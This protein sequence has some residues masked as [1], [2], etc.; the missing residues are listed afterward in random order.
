MAPSKERPGSE[1]AIAR[2][3]EALRST[4]G[5]AEPLLAARELC[6]V[7]GTA[8]NSADTPVASYVDAAL[9]LAQRALSGLR[10]QRVARAQSA[11]VEPLAELDDVAAPLDLLLLSALVPEAE[12]W[13]SAPATQQGVIALARGALELASIL[14]LAEPPSAEAGPPAAEDAA[15]E[16]TPATPAAITR[17][18]LS[19]AERTFLERSLALL[20]EAAR[21][22]LV[23]LGACSSGLFPLCLDVLREPALGAAADGATDGSPKSGAAEEGQDAEAPAAGSPEGGAPEPPTGGGQIGAA[24]HACALLALARCAESASARAALRGAGVFGAQLL[25]LAEHPEAGVRSHALL[26]AGLGAHDAQARS[27]LVGCGLARLVVRQLGQF[28]QRGVGLPAAGAGAPGAAGGADGASTAAARAFDALA[29]G[30]MA[31]AVCVRADPRSAAPPTADQALHA[32]GA[33]GGATAAALAGLRALA[34]AAN[35]A[36]HELSP[37][38]AQ[39]GAA[40]LPS[41]LLGHLAALLEFA[42]GSPGAEQAVE[43]LGPTAAAELAAALLGCC[44]LPRAGEAAAES[45]APLQ[46]EVPLVALRALGHALRSAAL[47]DAAYALDAAPLLARLLA[48]AAAPASAGAAAA[49]AAPDAELC[50]AAA[51]AV[52]AL[53]AHPDALARLL[54]PPSDALP[55]LASLLLL[56]GHAEQR[57]AATAVAALALAPEARVR[58]CATRDAADAAS[59]TEA[60]DTDALVSRIAPALIGR[61]LGS[62]DASV[63]QAGAHALG[64]LCRGEGEALWLVEEGAVGALDALR[65][66]SAPT[67]GAAAATSALRQLARRHA[68]TS[69]WLRR[70][71]PAHLRVARDALFYALAPGSPFL[72]ARD[73]VAGL[74]LGPNGAPTREVLTASA[75]SDAELAGLLA[76]CSA[77]LAGLRAGEE[78]LAVSL[79]AAAVCARMGG[80]VD[81]GGY[82]R[83]SCAH[84]VH[85]AQL[86]AGSDA[87]PLA[88]LPAGRAWHRAIL[89]KVL[90]DLT[91]PPQ[92]PPGGLSAVDLAQPPL[93]GLSASM[94]ARQAER[95]AHL[96]HAW[97]EVVL[98]GMRRH[99]AGAGGA[100]RGRAAGPLARPT[101]PARAPLLSARPHC[102]TP[103]GSSARSTPAP[104]PPQAAC[105]SST[106]CTRWGGRTRSARRRPTGERRDGQRGAPAPAPAWFDLIF[107]FSTPTVPLSSSPSSLPPPNTLRPRRLRPH[108]YCLTL[109]L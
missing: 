55:P 49:A 83:Y 95:G 25:A 32:H 109:T 23:K 41:G 57:E 78:A 88:R 104:L 79:L 39:G 75:A 2:Q 81:Y 24:A 94:Q 85:A 100:R 84:A 66:G 6:A 64:S 37:S 33:A 96:G 45:A 68:P 27:A 29:N 28:A 3:I 20:A 44:R 101:Q 10:A 98:D 43:D 17:P 80:P 107:P 35:G 76:R 86:A 36:L 13:T 40:A 26:L 51:F 22:P 90:V 38:S 34:G 91:Q 21:H 92:S 46:G 73:V 60:D 106:C 19:V 30:A 72:R 105:A 7:L 53:A 70:G 1:A 82:E 8:A 16:A 56:G 42:L 58:I 50:A 63:R 89:F 77:E 4:E 97:N 65:A 48:A 11:S 99:G 15:L 52:G 67:S 47:R 87:V 69:L 61:L 62:D 5:L 54:A 103:L 74:A 18:A 93:G 102:G 9:S 14:P 108:R 71:V 12:L 59:A 31:L